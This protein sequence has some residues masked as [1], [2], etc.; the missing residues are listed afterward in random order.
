MKNSATTRSFRKSTI[1]EVAAYAGVSTTTVSL[2]VSGRES[3]CSPETAERIRAAVTKL[4][5]TPSSLTRGLRQRSSTTIGV[6]M[7][8]PLD[9][10]VAFGTPFFE[11]LWRGIMHQAD[12]ENYSLL[13]YPASVRDGVG[14]EEFLDGRIDGLLIHDHENRRA[15]HLAEA[16]MQVVML[17]RSIDLP[18]GCGAAW[19]DENLI[20]ELALAHLWNLGHR[21]IAHVA[22]PVGSTA[23]VP[24]PNVP[25]ALDNDDVS[26]QRY[27]AYTE[28]M[29][30]RGEYDPRLVGYAQAWSAPQA[31][32]MLDAWRGL[33]RPPTAVF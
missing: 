28:W 11:G 17:T 23:G 15:Q 20:V 31:P 5:Y 3:V 9:F 13:H 16:G 21:R 29:R 12:Q 8:N 33:G 1:K 30:A 7:S 4:N 19:T 27:E 6:C 18:E 22:G 26:Y 32:E 25:T 2:F 24:M 10:G 14:W